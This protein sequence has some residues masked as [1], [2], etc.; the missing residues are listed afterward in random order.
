MPDPILKHDLSADF[1]GTTVV[2][3][4]GASAPG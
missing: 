3:L 4:G 1:F 2:F